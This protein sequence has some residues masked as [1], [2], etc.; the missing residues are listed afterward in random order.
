MRKPYSIVLS[1]PSLFYRL[2]KERSVIFYTHESGDA[3]RRLPLFLCLLNLDLSSQYRN[4][5]KGRVAEV[6]VVLK[7]RFHIEQKRRAI[8]DITKFKH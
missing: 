7:L 2:L 1:S 3:P 4:N 8:E 5:L 6:S